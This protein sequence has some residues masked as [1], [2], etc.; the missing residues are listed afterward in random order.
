MTPLTC[1]AK[2]FQGGHQE[3]GPGEVH[4]DSEEHYQYTKRHKYK[5]ATVQLGVMDMQTHVRM[6]PSF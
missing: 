3:E 2:K 1:P 6:T 5:I 4:H